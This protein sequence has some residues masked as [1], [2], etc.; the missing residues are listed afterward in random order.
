MLLGMF[1]DGYLYLDKVHRSDFPSL[2]L[3]V[4]AKVLGLPPKLTPDTDTS[5]AYY[6]MGVRLR[7][8]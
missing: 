3:R 5:P 7:C 2:G 6:M 1:A 8:P 4:V